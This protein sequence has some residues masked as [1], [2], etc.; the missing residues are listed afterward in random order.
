MVKWTAWKPI[1][2]VLSAVLF[3]HHK[4]LA[5]LETT[6]L[7]HVCDLFDTSLLQFLL[8]NQMRHQQSR[9]MPQQAGWQDPACYSRVLRVV[10]SDLQQ[11]DKVFEKVEKKGVRSGPLLRTFMNQEATLSTHLV[12]HMTLK[13]PS[14]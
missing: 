10:C 9:L 14:P 12:Y 8:A 3:S 6:L 1:S 7:G 5:L 13:F 11:S 2:L 4:P